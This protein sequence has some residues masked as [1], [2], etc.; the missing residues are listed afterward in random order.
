MIVD[1]RLYFPLS[2]TTHFTIDKT[3]MFSRYALEYSFHNFNIPYLSRI[4]F[5]WIT[6]QDH[7]V[8]LFPNLNGSHF[9]LDAENL[10]CG[11]GD[12]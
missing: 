2:V 7:Q 3:L 4:H 6:V 12:A 1:C 5:Q 10:S 9:V 11:G 8:C